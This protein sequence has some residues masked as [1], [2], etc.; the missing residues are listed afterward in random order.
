MQIGLVLGIRA[1]DR[2][3]GG[4]L[5][6]IALPIGSP[7]EEAEVGCVEFIVLQEF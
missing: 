3:N 6:G 2:L 5:R 7:A 1:L 4:R